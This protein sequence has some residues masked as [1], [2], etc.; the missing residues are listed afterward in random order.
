MADKSASDKRIDTLL[1]TA[2]K[3]WKIADSAEAEQRSKALE[4]IRFA[5]GDQWPPEMK[6]RR[7]LDG[8]PCLTINR[9]PQFVQHITNEERQNPTS[10][11]INPVGSGADKDT[12][13]VLQG[14][15]RHIENQS[16]ADEAYSNAFDYAVKGGWGFVRVTTDYADE[17]SFEQEIYIK[18][19][20]NPFSVYLDP[21][22]NEGDASDSEWGFVVCD[23]TKEQ[24]KDKFPN[25]KYAG[26]TINWVSTGDSWMQKDSIRVAEYFYRESR[27]EEIVQTSDGQVYLKKVIPKLPNGELMLPVGITIIQKRKTSVPFVKWALINND[28]VLEEQ[29]WAGKWIPIVRVIG[30]MTNINGERV[31]KGIVRDARDPQQQLNFMETAATEAIALAPKAPFIGTPKM[32]Q[33]Y[34]KQWGSMNTA[35][36]AYLMVNPDPAMP[37]GLPQRQ[38]AEPPIQAMMLAVRQASDD[39]KSTAGIYDAALGAGANDVSGKAILARQQQSQISA[40]HFGDNLQRAKRQVGRILIDIIPFI[41]NTPNRVIRII[42]E[43]GTQDNVTVNAK[44]DEAGNLPPGVEN[45]YDLTTG[46]YDVTVSTGPSYQTKRQEAVDT[47]LQLLKTDP[48]LWSVIGDL[49]VGNMDIPGSRE[50]ADRLKTMLPPA[51]AAMDQKQANIP[52]EAQ[53]MIVQLQTQLQQAQQAA[54]AA[55]EEAKYG[56]QKQQMEL[57]SK[58][59]IAF[60]QMELDREKVQAS[61]IN[62][63]L[64]AKA[65]LAQSDA[66]R[67]M[68]FI[69]DEIGRAHELGMN[70]VQHEQNQQMQQPQE[71]VQ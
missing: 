44:P 30:Q 1:E 58:E 16:N 56:I 43:D 60:G 48:N 13:D 24:Y 9:I 57:E 11:Q 59:R 36:R 21:G 22:G 50:I 66:E 20:E 4:D 7:Q 45:I 41:Y 38:T 53:Q 31:Y 28:E 67:E 70:A 37:G 12:A 42:G 14:L 32:F 54:Q 68:Q 23:Y 61:I 25:S 63:E 47:Q 64:A 29:E 65:E 17:L 52:P 6:Q 19:V 5:E 3:R 55:A 8:R 15:V 71:P 18:K 51:I 2:K 40:F 26:D 69:S 10:L 46:K 35:N 34:E 49:V 33:G 27:E 62:A 39:L